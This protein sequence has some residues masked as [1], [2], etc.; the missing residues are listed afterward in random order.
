MGLGELNGPAAALRGL[1]AD[2][3]VDETGLITQETLDQARID[4]GC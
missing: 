2:A 3:L 1:L 4:L